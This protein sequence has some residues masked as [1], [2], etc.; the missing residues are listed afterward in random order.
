MNADFVGAEALRYLLVMLALAA[1]IA[2]VVVTGRASP[3]ALA[4]AW[5][6][7]DGEWLDVWSPDRQFATQ[8]AM[9]APQAVVQPSYFMPPPVEHPRWRKRASQ[10]QRY[11]VPSLL[12]QSCGQERFVV[13]VPDELLLAGVVLHDVLAAC[14]GFGRRLALHDGIAITVPRVA[15]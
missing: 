15:L 1:I 9:V 4:Q 2:G 11:A 13:D 8:V 6:R 3:G 12:K 14:V 7:E 5:V 10:P